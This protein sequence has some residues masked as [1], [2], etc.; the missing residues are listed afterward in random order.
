MADPDA[1]ATAVLLVRAADGQAV[2]VRRALSARPGLDVLDEVLTTHEAISSAER[3][4]PQVLVM[5]VRLGDVAG[6]GVLRSIRRAAPDTRVVLH[7]RSSDV[8]DPPGTRR[9]VPQLV[10]VTLDPVRPAALAARLELPGEPLSV[11]MARSFVAELLGEWDLDGLVPASE[12]LVSEL[13]ANAVQH[14]PGRCAV[15]LICHADV[16][17]VAVSDSGPGMPDP[18]VMSPSSERGRGLHIV[19]AF[20]ADW[21]VDQLQDGRKQ[22]WA[23]LDPAEVY[24]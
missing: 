19:S 5:D 12:L 13:V 15:E 17:R 9:W 4:Q 6:Q 11:P 18:R 8:D 24:T 7:A 21:G 14:V 23:E 3:L 22:V 1:P 20:S 2:S 16:L 10:D